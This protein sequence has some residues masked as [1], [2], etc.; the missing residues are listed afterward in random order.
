MVG[1]KLTSRGQTTI[2]KRIRERLQ[3]EPG[4]RVLF[5]ERDGEIVLQPVR[6]TL[7]D[8]RGSV[9]PRKPGQDFDQVRREVKEEVARRNVDE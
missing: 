4:D 5:L 7:R 1:S 2:P 9:K 8:L 6:H 3:L